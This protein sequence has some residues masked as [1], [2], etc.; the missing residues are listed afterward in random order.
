[1]SGRR[2]RGGSAM[3]SEAA[4]RRLRQYCARTVYAPPVYHENDHGRR[5]RHLHPSLW[6][7]VWNDAEVRNALL[8]AGEDHGAFDD[9]VE[10]V[11]ADEGFPLLDLVAEMS[12]EAKEREVKR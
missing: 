8:A 7:V 4:L 9:L 1:M 10:E 11:C 2:S 3:L 6:R 5:V 12:R